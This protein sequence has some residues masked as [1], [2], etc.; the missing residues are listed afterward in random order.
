MRTLSLHRITFL[1]G[2]LIFLVCFTVGSSA[3]VVA[4]H[5]SPE[6]GAASLSASANPTPSFGHAIGAPGMTERAPVHQPLPDPADC[7]QGDHTLT[8]TPS[9]GYADA[10][11]LKDYA[12]L[13]QEGGGTLQLGAG[14][15]YVNQTLDFQK[16]GNFSIQGAGMGKTILSLPPSPIGNFSADN[17]TLVGLYNTTLNA[18]VDGTTANLIQTSGPEPINNF[19]ICNLTVDGQANNAANDWS[20]SFIFDGSGGYHH[21]FSDIAEVG[22]FGPS[23]TPNGLHLESGSG[24]SVAGNDYVVEN[25]EASN[26]SLPYENY[27]GFKGGPNFLNVGSVTNCTIDGVTGIGLVAFEVAPPTGCL[28]ENW[29]ISGRIV[30]DPLEGGSWGNTVIDNVTV[31]PNGTAAQH[32]LVSSVPDGNGDMTSNFTGLRWQNDTFYGTVQ[33]GVNMVDVENSTFYGGLNTTPAIFDGNRV[34]QECSIHLPVPIRLD[35]ST[36]GGI[37]ST[38]I[39]DTFIFYNGTQGSDLFQ[40]TVPVNLWA[41]DTV[42]IS[43][44]GATFVLTGP[45]ATL[46]ENS[47]FTSLSYDS[48]GDDS[49]PVLLLFDS[50][51]SPG[52]VDQGAWVGGLSRITNDLPSLRPATPG[53][54]TIDWRNATA[55]DVAWSAAQGPVSNY[56]LYSGG[57]ATKLGPAYSVGT[58]TAYLVKGL[59]PS[60]AYCFAVEAWNSTYHSS[61]GPT[62][63]T[64]TAPLDLYVPSTPAGLAVSARGLTNLTVEWAASSG[65]VTNYTLYSGPNATA[66]SAIGSTGVNTTF[67]ASGLA[68]STE[69]YFAVQ[70]WNAS[71]HSSVSAPVNGTTYPLSMFVP[72]TPGTPTVTSRGLTVIGL[73]W[74]GANGTVTNYTVFW[75]T[76]PGS[77]SER[78]SAGDLTSSFVTGLTPG[79]AYSFAVEAWNGSSFHSSL[80]STMSGSTDPVTPSTPGTPTGLSVVSV[81]L[82]SIGLRWLPAVGSVTNYTVFVGANASTL[83]TD[84][85]VGTSTG[86]L[87]TD[88]TPD[89]NYRFAVEAWNL[90]YPSAL[91]TEVNASTLTPTVN[92]NPGSGSTGSTGPS[93]S[94]GAALILLTGT[95][96]GVVAAVVGPLALVGW[97]RAGARNA[98]GRP[99]RAVV[100]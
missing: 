56:T 3:A 34:I 12:T 28:I 7:A 54:I 69:Y 23:T 88:L 16:Y 62:I 78:T 18:A 43:G 25:L 74:S 5:G 59:R 86:Y 77:L 67:V 41:N 93:G 61:V 99:R 50:P 22:F 20:G 97:V 75:G 85:S 27:P 19:E 42:E 8:L 44:S 89:T 70:A 48:L 96:L 38:L 66:L 73:R 52:F 65:P 39:G 68:P 6:P 90:T 95:L 87:V 81:G 15:F 55:I 13:G 21:V 10:A 100:R 94:S 1:W 45:N 30:I 82:D 17:G 53:S 47:S 33:G 51:G 80:S 35:G 63:C 57:S 83:S 31:N 98:R 40:L 9:T 84:I 4:Q 14:V 29:N 26:N 2:A 32:P 24:G 79:T 60:S 72:G 71:F 49:P 11:L 37:T 91:S 58:E 46:T 92:S 76:S 36:V 64:S